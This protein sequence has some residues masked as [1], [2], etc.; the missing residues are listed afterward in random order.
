[1]QL[2]TEHAAVALPPAVQL[3]PPLARRRP[4]AVRRATI[5]LL[6]W[7]VLLANAAII[8]VLWLRGG[9]IS[10]VH[11]SG[12]LMTSIGRITG[13]LGAYSALIQVLLLARLPWLERL[14]GFD[15]LSVWHRWNGH[16]CLDLVV[17][18]TLFI[19]LGYAALDRLSVGGEI[20]ALLTG[21]PGMITATIGTALLVLVV[22]SSVVIA[23]KRLRYELWYL[24][25]LSAYAGIALAWT[26]QIPTGNELVLD[27]LAANYWRGLYVATL[28]LLIGFR[29]LPP[30]VKALRYRMR[31]AEVVEEAPGVVS[32]RI[33]G[34]GLARL[35]ARPGQFFLWR[36]L[37]RHRWWASHPFSLSAAPADDSLRITVKDLGDFSR[38]LG[39][40][41][42][43]TRVVA[44][45]PFGVFTDSARRRDKVALVAGGIGI[46]PIRGLLEEMSGDVVVL[47][48]VVREEDIVFRSELERL[49]HER[50]FTVK[51]VVG[52]HAAPGGA[53][54]MSPEHL[55]ELV[56]DLRE[57]EIYV[58]GPAG[59]TDFLKRNIRA[60]GVPRKYVHT[61]RFAL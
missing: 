46:T 36:F 27:K 23:R 52:D 53:R 59:M 42:P 49:S 37:D 56:P 26:H 40:I 45:G 3:A 1:M 4:Q 48:R 9:G 18:H 6:L 19:T 24:V 60:A 38:G 39:T 31:V 58:C 5:A 41:R 25:H 50:G 61:E 34:R 12:E 20:G 14:V 7:T 2:E 55:L 28:A 47:Y 32:L 44:E 21:Y 33:A 29:V 17:A 51:Y 54:L 15:R 13:L 57:R 8:V 22:A 43:G 16:A 35:R 30:V 10:D 11:N